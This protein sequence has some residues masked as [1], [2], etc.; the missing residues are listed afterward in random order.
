MLL[1]VCLPHVIWFTATIVLQEKR[2]S[3]EAKLKELRGTVEVLQQRQALL[4]KALDAA[5]AAS[6]RLFQRL[7]LTAPLQEE[8][9]TCRVICS[10]RHKRTCKGCR[11]VCLRIA[12]PWCCWISPS[13]SPSVLFTMHYSHTGFMYQCRHPLGQLQALRS[14]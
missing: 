9:Q 13:V 6:D 1:N 8:P 4:Q 11:L 5:T 12:C 2:G 3:Q 10:Q 14:R 7:H